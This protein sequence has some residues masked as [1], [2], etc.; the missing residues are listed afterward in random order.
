MNDL[1]DGMVIPGYRSLPRV[2]PNISTTAVQLRADVSNEDH[3]SFIELNPTD[4][5][6]NISTTGD[7]NVITAVN[8]TAN[9]TTSVSITSPITTIHGDLKVIGNTEFTGSVKANGKVIDDTHTHG[10]VQPGSGNTGTVN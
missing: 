2:L 10:N 4:Y 3:H 6:V 7:V 9:A 5:N 8:I 1:S